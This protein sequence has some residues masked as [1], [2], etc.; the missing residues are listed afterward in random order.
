MSDETTTQLDDP[1]AALARAIWRSM[2]ET[3][4]GETSEARREAWNSEKATA[5]KIAV[6]VLRRLERAGVAVTKS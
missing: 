4:E 1:K 2:R 5:A 6:Q 3:P